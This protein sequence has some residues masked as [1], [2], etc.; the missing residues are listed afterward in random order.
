MMGACLRRKPS[1]RLRPVRGMKAIVRDVRANPA[2]WHR[3]NDRFHADGLTALN[4]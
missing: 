4:G 2:T 1:A 3:T